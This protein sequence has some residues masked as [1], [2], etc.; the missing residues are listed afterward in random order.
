[1]TSLADQLTACSPLSVWTASCFLPCPPRFGISQNGRA[2]GSTPPIRQ[3]RVSCFQKSCYFTSFTFCEE[4]YYLSWAINSEMIPGWTVRPFGFRIGPWSVPSSDLVAWRRTVNYFVPCCLHRHPACLHSFHRRLGDWSTEYLPYCVD[5]A[6]C[7]SSQA[8]LPSPDEAHCT[9]FR[10]QFGLV[11]SAFL[12]QSGPSQLK[13]A[14]SHFLQEC[15]PDSP[16]SI[17]EFGTSATWILLPSRVK[18]SQT[19]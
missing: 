2:H 7:P 5:I 10:E 9:H 8:C 6:S 18:F 17:I 3:S 11:P 12:L 14:L 4:H 15:Y 19:H 16:S 1:M 13:D